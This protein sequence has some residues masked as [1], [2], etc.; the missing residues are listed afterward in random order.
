MI[1]RMS[2]VKAFDSYK[3]A[4]FCY[5]HGDISDN[6]LLTADWSVSTGDVL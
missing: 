6:K 1:Q 5:P 2:E 3:L 4:Y